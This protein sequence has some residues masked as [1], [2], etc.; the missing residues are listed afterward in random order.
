MWG[1]FGSRLTKLN[2]LTRKTWKRRSPGGGGEIARGGSLQG[3]GGGSFEPRTPE[4]QV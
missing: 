1:W 2:R 4:L 3:G